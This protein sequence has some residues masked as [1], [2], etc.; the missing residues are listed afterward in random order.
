MPVLPI[1]KPKAILVTEMGI[2]ILKCKKFNAN[3]TTVL[4]RWHKPMRMDHPEG[5][6]SVWVIY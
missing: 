1:I 2:D 6:V 5:Y 4:P 3:I